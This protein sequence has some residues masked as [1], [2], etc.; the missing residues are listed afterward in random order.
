V[1]H[2][3]SKYQIELFHNPEDYSLVVN[4]TSLLGSHFTAVKL[5]EGMGGF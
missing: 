2:F 1:E 4:Q 3:I 5:F